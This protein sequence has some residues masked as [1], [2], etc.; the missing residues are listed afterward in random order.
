MMAR[1]S[2]NRFCVIEA[3]SKS[4]LG[5]ESLKMDNTADREIASNRASGELGAAAAL[6]YT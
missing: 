5:N 6:R 3:G 4:A 2:R 1:K